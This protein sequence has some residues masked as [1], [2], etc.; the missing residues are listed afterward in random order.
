ME[1]EG[2]V[3]GAFLVLTV[4]TLGLWIRHKDSCKMVSAW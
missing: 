1:R 4:A 2:D 3:I